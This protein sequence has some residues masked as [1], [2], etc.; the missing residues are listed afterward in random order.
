MS[1]TKRCYNRYYNILLNSTDKFRFEL[2]G[3][4]ER[5]VHL[6]HFW[7]ID[8]ASELDPDT[9]SLIY[10]EILPFLDHSAPLYPF[11]SNTAITHNDFD[12]N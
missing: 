2:T 11:L 1:T 7:D 12:I 10:Q 5:S 4:V 3:E 6:H 8:S 9:Q